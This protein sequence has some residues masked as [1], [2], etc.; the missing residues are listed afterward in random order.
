M[1][2]KLSVCKTEGTKCD[3]VLS[4]MQEKGLEE[5]NQKGR[6]EIRISCEPFNYDR[7]RDIKEK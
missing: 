6:I 4:L 3:Y 2:K 5:W 1:L 7:N